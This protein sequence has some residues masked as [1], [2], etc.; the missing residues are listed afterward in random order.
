VKPSFKTVTLGCKVNQY[1]T[2]YVRQGLLRAGFHEAAAEEPADLCIVNTC[3]VT[4]ESDYKSR[5]IIRALSRENPRTEI[6][7]M[8]C[9]AARAPEELA[10]L[11]RV[12]H[13]MTDKRR[14][15]HL[16]AQLGRIDAPEGISSF[17]RL[18]RAYVKVQDGCTMGCAYCIVPKVRPTLLSRPVEQVV[19]EVRRLVEAGHCEV[20]LTGI[21]LGF[22]GAEFPHSGNGRTDL[23]ALGRR[24]LS[25]Q[26]EFRVRL[27]SLEAAEVGP[28]LLDLMAAHPDRIC[29][30][31]HI[32]LQSGSD[33]VLARMRRRWTVRQFVARCD[34]IRRRLDEPAL[35]TDVIVGFPGESEADF[36]AS[37]RVVRE[38]GFS[39][40]HVFRFSAREGTEA[41]GLPDQLPPPVKRRRAEALVAIA[42]ELRLGFARKLVGKGLQVVGEAVA[43]DRP[44]MLSGTADRYVTVQFP[45][46]VEMMGWIVRV[47]ADRVREDGVLVGKAEMRGPCA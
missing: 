19:E 15:A 4:L 5:K 30:H 13:V 33:G 21:H 17:D 36:E 28:D 38:V 1:E 34:E 6:I 22:Y 9:Y 42:R 29:P 44:G 46:G 45:A 47:T 12:I 25:V 7:V 14:L 35:T 8:G 20:V 10:R 26:G 37:C 43:P 24:I 11:P 23:A 18:H 40:V 41:A 32:P 3:T 27:S 16:V 2:E 31:L 39:R